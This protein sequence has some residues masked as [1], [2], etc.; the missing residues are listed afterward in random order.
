MTPSCH[1]EAFSV[2]LIIISEYPDVNRVEKLTEGIVLA[3][4]GEYADFQEATRKM[5]ELTRESE[6][7]DDNIHFTVKDYANYLSR[8]CYEKRN[9]QNPYYN[10]FVIAGFENGESFLATVDMYGSFIKNDYVAIGFSKHFGLALIANEWNPN[11]TYEE[12]KEIIKKCFSI[13][14]V[15]VCQSIDR[16]QF[17]FV[18]KDGAVVHHPEKIESKWDFKEFRDRKNERLWQ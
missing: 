6:S 9:N 10:N 16:V 5:N 7:Y 8:I 11:K 1:T 14:Y 4:T 13:I 12:C 17:T 2:I 3:G 15:R 18:G